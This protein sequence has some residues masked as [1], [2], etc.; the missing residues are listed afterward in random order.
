MA[1]ILHPTI[2]ISET[3]LQNDPGTY[4]LTVHDTISDLSASQDVIL[5]A[6]TSHVELQY[7]TIPD[8]GYITP[9]QAYF[10]FKFAPN[11]VS[12]KVTLKK[13]KTLENG[14]QHL[15][16]KSNDDGWFFGIQ[17]RKWVCGS[18]TEYPSGRGTVNDNT[19]YTN[20]VFN[21]VHSGRSSVTVN[22]VE[23][24]YKTGSLISST[25]NLYSCMKPNMNATC[26]LVGDWY[27]YTLE[28]GGQTISDTI[29][30]RR[31]DGVVC[32][33]DTVRSIYITPERG[34][35]IAGPNK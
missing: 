26:G 13:Y 23:Q 5:V 18:T 15:A 33:Y 11:L 25:S 31:N 32:F 20:V 8:N 17:D 3:L 6:P 7:L 12:F 28:S 9:N 27:G 34:T 16:G 19:L 35:F 22:G 29:P 2:E 30:V 10:D 21:M 4:T 1:K 24:A 14:W